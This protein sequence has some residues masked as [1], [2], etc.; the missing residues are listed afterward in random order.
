M[1]EALPVTIVGGY[2]GSGKT[3]LVNHLL[4]NANG[5]RIAVMVNDF[6]ELPIDADLIEAQDGD[7]ISL[8]GGCIC[9]SYGDDLSLS[10]QKLRAQPTLPDHI[11]I[12]ASGWGCFTWRYRQELIVAA[13]V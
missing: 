7:V 9:C 13:C 5:V 8:S 2:L 3:T 10:L 12:E 4:R 1:S 6:G 11:V